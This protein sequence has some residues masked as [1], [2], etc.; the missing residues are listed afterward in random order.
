M[1]GID[2]TLGVMRIFFVRT[3]GCLVLKHVESVR[4][5]I[6]IS[7]IEIALEV[8]KLEQAVRDMVILYT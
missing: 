5:T 1:V 6:F 2:A 3:P 8:V 7:L 4:S